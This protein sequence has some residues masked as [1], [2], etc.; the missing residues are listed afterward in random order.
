METFAIV[1][2]FFGVTGA[3]LLDVYMPHKK[4]FRESIFL[5]IIPLFGVLTLFIVT[6]GIISDFKEEIEKLKGKK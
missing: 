5:L 6:A 2:L 3:Y 4:S 1:W